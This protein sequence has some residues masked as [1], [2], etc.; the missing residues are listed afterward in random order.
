[1]FFWILSLFLLFFLAQ[2]WPFFFEGNASKSIKENAAIDPQSLG[3]FVINLDRSIERYASVEGP[4]K[5]LGYPTERISAVDGKAL[6]PEELARVAD[7]DGFAKRFSKPAQ[8]GMIGCSLSHF[9]AWEALLK[10]P[11]AYGLIFEDDVSFDGDAMKTVLAD[12]VHHKWDICMLSISHRGM[13]LTVAGLPLG[14]KLCVYL[15]DVTH[16]SG[17]LINRKAAEALLTKAL[18]IRMPIDHYFTRTWEFGLTL[19][20]VENP[21][22]VHQ[23]FGDSDIGSTQRMNTWDQS[24]WTKLYRIGFRLN[25]Y[26]MRFLSGLVSYFRY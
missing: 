14:H 6:P 23:T 20:G 2:L 12:L 3:V 10:S 4:I 17:Y 19:T 13:P 25:A 18:P 5:A 21:R 24:L 16:G 8:A 11:Y 15:A 9:K 22:L 1:M 7:W 26:T